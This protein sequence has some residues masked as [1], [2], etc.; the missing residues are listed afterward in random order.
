MHGPYRV[1]GVRPE[2]L[3]ILQEG[4]ENSVSI[5]RVARVT[6]E[7]GPPYVPLPKTVGPNETPRQLA[8]KLQGINEKDYVLERVFHDV[9]T[10]TGPPHVVG[11]YGY[12]SKYDSVKPSEHLPKHFVNAY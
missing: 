11:W 1:L 10:K 3:Q 6:K 12:S 9:T 8:T 4:V 2:Y 7:G 5:N